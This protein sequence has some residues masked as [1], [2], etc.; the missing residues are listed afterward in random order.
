M[1]STDI[2]AEKHTSIPTK[3]VETIRVQSIINPESSK[4]AHL[5]N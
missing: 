5:S 1:I 4:L 3:D 2:L